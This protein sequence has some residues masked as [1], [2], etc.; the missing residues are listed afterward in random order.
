MRV[1]ALPLNGGLRLVT[2]AARRGRAV[3]WRQY[4][5][6]RY[7]VRRWTTRNATAIA[8]VLL[9]ILTA[10]AFASIPTVQ[11][12]VNPLFASDDHLATLRSLLV[13]LGG[14]LVGATAIGF[15]VVMFAVQMNFARMPH[16]LF[17]GL[18]TDARLLGAF[19]ST[20]VL[21][22]AVASLSLIPDASWVG[23]GLVAAGW[24]MVLIL[25]LF[26][27]A[28]RRALSLIN[29]LQQLRFVFDRAR[30][31]IRAWARSAQ[32]AGPLLER[33]KSQEETDEAPRLLRSTH[34]LSRAAYFRANPHWTAT[35]R[36]AVAHA[37]SFARRYAEEGDYEVAAAALNVV[38][39][40]NA[41]YVE[42]KGK[43]FFSQPLMLDN[44][45]A[46]D[47]FINETLEHLR[48]H[49]RTA[50]TRGDEEQI[51]QTFRALASLV[52]IYIMI[53]Y[54]EEYA[55]EKQHAQLAAGYLSGAV[56]AVLSHDMPDVLMEGIMLMGQSAQLFLAAAE[57]N[58]IV[59]LAEKIA[60]LG[61]SGVVK[62]DFRPVTSTAMEQLAQL[63][64]ALIGT[65]AHDIRFA[66]GELKKSVASLV[67]LFLTVPD[68][69]LL[70]AHSAY[71][72]PYYSLTKIQTLG[73]RLTDLANALANAPVGDKAAADIINNVDQWAEELHPT[74][75]ELLLVA[76]EKR[77]SF[78]F[79][80][81]HWIA[82]VTKVLIVIAQA[83]A[84]EDYVQKDIIKHA[85]W[86]I[87][88]LSWI[89]DDKDTAT[90]V[91]NYGM[92][93]TL[94]EAALDALDRDCDKVFEDARD[95]LFSW[96]FKAGRHHVGYAILE[97][98][99]YGLATLALWKDGFDGGPRLKTT[100]A[101][102]LAKG[103]AP[104][105]ELRDRAAR[106][107]RR[108]SETL[109]RQEHW[110]SRIENAMS[111]I[112]QSRLRPL[113]RTIADLL[114]P[115]TANEPISVDIY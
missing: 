36:Q 31:D 102:A 7:H 37:V 98:S 87:S 53:D 25:L 70:S 96:A 44:P 52:R 8:T 94:F 69:P 23:A 72:A 90:F 43:T 38:V 78:T 85:R 88:V 61:I 9:V 48:Q 97:R 3:L 22:I 17:R 20:F 106:E 24:A 46:T 100:I 74:E 21:A 110:A 107:L 27:F 13:A 56:E 51:E 35:S 66:V 60:A 92:T 4:F 62:E 115:G 93:E 91:E 63:T 49:A 82:H 84:C 79:D 40:I 18:S 6:A 32:R 5:F 105:Q 58:G 14:A 108:R 67:K 80:M 41:A 15:S 103:D 65:K 111:R 89:P 112:D 12:A 39:A 30:R 71:L 54:S 95:L 109:Y 101:A 114:S 19:A 45:L 2:R 42:A 34:D 75:K 47:G 59:T 55:R 1:R 99:M 113:M 86:L 81:I 33:K 11:R 76:I 16:G 10:A 77:S 68:R 73:A 29:P 26:L 83:P 57:P 64:F 28:Y 50:M 104:D